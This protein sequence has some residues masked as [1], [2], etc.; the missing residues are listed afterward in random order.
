MR[1]D[2]CGDKG[3]VHAWMEGAPFGEMMARYT[4][5]YGFNQH[6]YDYPKGLID[7][8]ASSHWIVVRV[9]EIVVESAANTCLQ[10]SGAVEPWGGNEEPAQVRGS[11]D[12]FLAH[13]TRMSTPRPVGG[14]ETVGA[15]TWMWP[16]QA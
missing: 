2:S 9:C 1:C 3:D 13:F 7:A 4:K 10:H 16:L 8:D 5:R 6:H 11:G 12:A 14:N 15:M